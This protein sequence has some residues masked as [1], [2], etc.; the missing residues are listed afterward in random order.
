MIFNL[1]FGSLLNLLFNFKDLTL[2]LI[3]IMEI[4]SLSY[5]EWHMS[6]QDF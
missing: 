2:K 1:Y 4:Y 5:H 6:V 3:N